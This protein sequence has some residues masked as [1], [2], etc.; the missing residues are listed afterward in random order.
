M[1]KILI[2]EDVELNLDL[3]VQLL[4]DE[5]LLL[6]ARD[7]RS[8]VK[9]AR[10]EKPD[11]IIMDMSL[12]ILDGWSAA[13]E[14]R[15]NQATKNI[16]IIALTAHALEGERQKALEA[17]CSAYLTKPVDERL[18]SKTIKSLLQVGA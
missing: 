12:P 8:G 17:G 13:H 18:L 4:E 1:K 6:S 3:L 5:Y 2:V 15:T 16:P 14:I 9:L 11:L 7:G 10:D